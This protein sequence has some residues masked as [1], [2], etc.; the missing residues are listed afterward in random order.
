MMRI[1]T[2]SMVISLSAGT[3]CTATLELIRGRIS[4]VLLGYLRHGPS[5]RTR[6]VPAGAAA[7]RRCPDGGRAGRPTR[8]RRAHRAAVRGPPDRPRRAGRVGARPLRRGPAPPPPP[9]AAPPAP[10][11]P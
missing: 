11:T 8:R 10:A 5:D 2:D 6:P 4:P 9:G 3:S 1:E 7:V